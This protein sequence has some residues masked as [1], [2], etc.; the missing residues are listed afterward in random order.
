M[1]LWYKFSFSVLLDAPLG[2]IP[3]AMSHHCCMLVHVIQVAEGLL[4]TQ[5][6]TDSSINWFYR[7]LPPN[8]QL[9]SSSSCSLG[10]GHKFMQSRGETPY[11][12][13]GCS[14]GP[15][16]SGSMQHDMRLS[17]QLRALLLA[18]QFISINV[19]PQ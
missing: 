11:A 17:L 8:R 14:P 15:R 7:H 9:F 12:G 13:C 2:E 5:T 18:P 1:L 6:S 19:K 16:P 4:R 10:P 3:P